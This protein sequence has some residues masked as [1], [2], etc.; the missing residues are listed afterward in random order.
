MPKTLNK[1]KIKCA[2]L[3]KSPTSEKWWDDIVFKTGGNPRLTSLFCEVLLGTT[4]SEKN[5]V[6]K[7]DIFS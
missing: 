7:H 2:K 5:Q 1:Y 3:L 4:N 6:L